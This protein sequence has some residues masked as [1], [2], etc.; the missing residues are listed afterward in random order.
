MEGVRDGGRVHQQEGEQQEHLALHPHAVPTMAGRGRVQ[1]YIEVET[2]MLPVAS[3]GQE[4]VGEAAA[5]A[6]DGS[7]ANHLT[8][9]TYIRTGWAG[10]SR[11]LIQTY[12]QGGR[13]ACVD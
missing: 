1:P 5:R 3:H 8:D 13:E 12:A 6:L 7:C 4:S 10:T 9:N 11:T 2:L